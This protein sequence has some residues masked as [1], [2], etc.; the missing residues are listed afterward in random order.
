MS[1]HMPPL[2]SID[3]SRYIMC[4]LHMLLN[5]VAKM[6]KDSILSEICDEGAATKLNN[7]LKENHIWIRYVGPPLP[8]T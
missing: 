6:W 3:P 2:C 7:Y 5:I 8:V 1:I 4:L